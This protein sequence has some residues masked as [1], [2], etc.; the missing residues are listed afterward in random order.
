M[1]RPDEHVEEGGHD[2]VGDVLGHDVRAVHL[3]REGG[4]DE[5]EAGLHREHAVPARCPR[6]CLQTISQR[7]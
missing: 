3:P 6:I 5:A 4:L 1:A 2:Q 7:F